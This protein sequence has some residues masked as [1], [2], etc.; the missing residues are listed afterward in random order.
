MFGPDLCRTIQPT[1]SGRVEQFDNQEVVEWG[2]LDF[3]IQVV[4]FLL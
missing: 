4:Q 3:P 2:T 1:L